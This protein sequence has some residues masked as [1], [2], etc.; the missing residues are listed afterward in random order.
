MARKKKCKCPPPGAP[1]WMVT[2]GDMMSLL[3]TFFILIVSFSTLKKEQEYQEVIKAIKEKF[4]YKGGVGKAPSEKTPENSII[5]KLEAVSSRQLTHEKLSRAEDPGMEGRHTTVKRVREGM[6]FTI[7]GRIAFEP[8]SAKLK[9]EAKT[10]LRKVIERTRGQ[11]N[12]VD[13]RG[14]AADYDLPPGTRF[15]NR[16]D[17]SYARAQSVRRFLIG[18]GIRG[19][20][21]R[22]VACA[23]TEPL[24]QRV[25][26]RAEAA[27]NRRIELIVTEALVADFDG[28]DEPPVGA[29][30]EAD[31]NSG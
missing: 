5:N 24:K 17:L 14:H 9:A 11:N 29:G 12:K 13:I 22:V 25:Y 18:E 31:S 23:N 1:D 7:G 30:S 10:A 28:G 21:L 3:L 8:G 20:R 19:E 6:R 27:V 16:W 4:G 2:Y 15:D 26:D